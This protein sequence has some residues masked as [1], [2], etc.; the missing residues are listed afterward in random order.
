MWQNRV[1]RSIVVAGLY[2]QVVKAT[3]EPPKPAKLESRKFGEV[4][5]HPCSVN[6][7][8]AK[9]ASPWLVYAWPITPWPEGPK[10]NM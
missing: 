5:A 3:I 4:K 2:P 10:A 6:F 1:V 7:E 8:K 9:F